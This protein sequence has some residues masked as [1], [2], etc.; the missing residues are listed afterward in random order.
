MKT[1]APTQH[2]SLGEQGES[3]VTA[4]L[5]AQGCTICALNYSC[6]N[7]EIDII[8]Q[9]GN[10]RLFVEVKTRHHHYFSTSQVITPTK[11]RKIVATAHHYNSIRGWGDNLVHR[12]DV[13]LLEQVENKLSI[14]Y[15]PN[16]FT[17]DEEHG[18][19]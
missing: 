19:W 8:A 13:A 1:I 15:I 14:T 2:R 5:K 18:R 10:V 3:A 6:K 17:P 12:F 4:Y 11:Q 7:G 16:A 9:K